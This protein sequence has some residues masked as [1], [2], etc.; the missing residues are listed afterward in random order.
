MPFFIA[1][2]LAGSI[3]PAVA[4]LQDKGRMP[5]G[6]A[7]FIVLVVLAL[8]TSYLLITIVAR[9]VAEL[10]E[11]GRL[12]P[13][14]RLTLIEMSQ[15]LLLRLQELHQSLPGPISENIQQGLN[16]FLKTSE[17]FARNIINRFLGAITFSAN[18]G[19]M[20]IITFLATYFL[21]KD[22]DILTNTITRHAPPRW[23]GW[24]NMAKDRIM[25]DLIGFIRAQF[26]LLMLSTIA[27]A[28]GLVL[29]KIR[30]WMTLALVIGILD[31]IP[32]VGPGL[33]L[34]PWSGVSFLFGH[35]SRGLGILALYGAIFLLRQ[36]LQ[37]KLFG[38]AAGIHPLAMLAALYAGV[39]FFGLKG[40]FIGPILAIIA[41]AIWYT[42]SHI[43]L[44]QEEA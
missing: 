23:Q 19:F 12:L 17:D 7:V 2:I 27:A 32:A 20:I 38:D 42:K 30:Y 33:I 36:S 29:L 37:P 13:A 9:M 6:I 21:S 41:K 43:P 18:I 44:D 28:I 40:A 15:Q 4:F 11:L 34:F 39:V 35:H 26:F 10:V 31:L 25:V 22:K 1:F 14:Y 8:L 16:T 24:M 3:E 5:R